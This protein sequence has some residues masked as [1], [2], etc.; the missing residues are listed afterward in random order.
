MVWKRVTCFLFFFFLNIPQL[1]N[2]ALNTGLNSQQGKN[3]CGFQ[4]QDNSKSNTEYELQ[5]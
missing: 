5:C 3:V 2:N 1:N 4:Q